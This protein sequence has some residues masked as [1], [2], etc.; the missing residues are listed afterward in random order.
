MGTASTADT[1][2]VLLRQQRAVLVE[3]ASGQRS[4]CTFG[5][6]NRGA[7]KAQGSIA[8]LG[9]C[10]APPAP[11]A[12]ARPFFRNYP[13]NNNGCPWLPA[14]GR[15]AQTAQTA[16]TAAA[17]CAGRAMRRRRHSATAAETAQG[18]S[19]IPSRTGDSSSGTYEQSIGQTQASVHPLQLP[20]PTMT[21]SEGSTPR[22]WQNWA[23]PSDRMSLLSESAGHRR[24]GVP[25]W[26]TEAVSTC[27]LGQGSAQGRRRQRKERR[28]CRCVRCYS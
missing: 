12:Q 11:D 15:T 28:L 19:G 6:R 22:S 20:P 18:H 27:A 4:Y 23:M 8:Q 24:E 17:G 9:A 26:G 25:G 3:W 2:L 21:M 10:P 1:S 13:S 7:S 5:G 16:L 14:P